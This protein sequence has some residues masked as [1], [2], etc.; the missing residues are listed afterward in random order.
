MANFEEII[1]TCLLIMCF[2][3]MIMHIVFG[4]VTMRKLRKNKETKES[5]GLEFVSGWDTFNVAQTL[6]MPKSW[7]KKL[8]KTPLFAMYANYDLLFNNTT[9]L[10]RILA[11][12]FWI[13]LFFSVFF[14]I[15]LLVVRFFF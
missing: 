10:D 13:P 2:F 6:S 9:L 14:S 7:S 8:E 15:F 11:K 1:F 12:V 3:V 5:L 4:Q